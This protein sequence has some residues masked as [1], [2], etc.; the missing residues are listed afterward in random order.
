V[1]SDCSWAVS[2]VSATR[3]ELLAAWLA[4]GIPGGWWD[5]CLCSACRLNLLLTVPMESQLLSLPYDQRA[6][7]AAMSSET[8]EYH[9]KKH[10]RG[11]A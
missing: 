10:C 3:P 6:L 4:V 9:Y 2:A 11:Y 8:L 1:E 7:A 5:G